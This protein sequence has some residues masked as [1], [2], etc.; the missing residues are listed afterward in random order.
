MVPLS[1]VA[2][3]ENGLSGAS[4]VW[5]ADTNSLCVQV[6]SSP[7][8][9]VTVSVYWGSGETPIENLT[10]ESF[11]LSV[12]SAGTDAPFIHFNSGR[13]DGS[14]RYTDNDAEIIWKFNI[15]AYRGLV[16]AAQLSQNYVLEVSGDGVNF[17][18]VINYSKI[19]SYSANAGTNDGVACVVVGA[20]EDVEEI[21]YIRLRNT[22]TRGG[23]GGAV[24]SL[25]F[26]Y[27]VQDGE[28][29][30]PDFLK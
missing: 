17:T 10:Y 6:F 4:Q 1:V 15:S 12:N 26:Q 18:E 24:K 25:T 8:M 30:G 5:D 19:S 3:Y 13:A 7:K 21:L 9:P 11:K 2:T 16:V 28:T 29:L 14:K 23:W 22:T 20:Y 27:L